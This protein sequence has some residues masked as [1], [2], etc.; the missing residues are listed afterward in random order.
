MAIQTRNARSSNVPSIY[1]LIFWTCVL[2]T[3]AGEVVADDLLL[4]WLAFLSTSCAGD[5]QSRKG[6]G[7][8]TKSQQTRLLCSLYAFTRLLLERFRSNSFSIISSIAA[9]SSFREAFCFT[10]SCVWSSASWTSGHLKAIFRGGSPL[11]KARNRW[12]AALTLLKLES[13]LW[14]GMLVAELVVDGAS[15]M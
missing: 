13:W 15:Q 12:A 8:Q 2:E 5:I 3:G 4:S 11:R 10:V 7:I 1:H 14:L 6:K 9:Q